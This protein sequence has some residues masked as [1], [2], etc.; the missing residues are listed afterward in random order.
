MVSASADIRREASTASASSAMAAVS[1]SRSP[2]PA[3]ACAWRDRTAASMGAAAA[4][5]MV[6]TGAA[7]DVSL[8]DPIV[9]RTQSAPIGSPP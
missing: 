9:Q 5:L 3:S 1:P 2:L 7:R 8:V 4:A 6:R